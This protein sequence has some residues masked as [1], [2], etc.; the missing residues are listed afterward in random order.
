MTNFILVPGMWLGA[1]A[2]DAVAEPLRRDGHTVT[3][4]TLGGLAERAAEAGTATLESHIADVVA[5]AGGHDEVTLVGHS[6]GGL[7]VRGAAD[8]LAGQVRRVVYVDSGP[9][10]DGVAQADFSPGDDTAA[11]GD[12]PPPSFDPADD[13]AMFAGLEG[14]SAWI[15]ERAT[16]HPRGSVVQP[17][18]LRSA[19]QPP[20]DL[21]CSTFTKETVDG[22]I[23]AGHPFFAGLDRRD[24]RVR[25]LPTGHWPMFSRPDDLAALLAG[26]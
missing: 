17:L 18:R 8:R 26:A 11:V 24:Y 22:M 10:P 3:A 21:V 1:W 13:P 7:P 2:W 16:P 6:Y 25:E 23:A 12:V 15:L 4:V 9:V 20:T 14:R 5:A 19:E